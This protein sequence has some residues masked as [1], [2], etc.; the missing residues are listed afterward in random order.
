MYFSNVNI[1]VGE[2]F[3]VEVKNNWFMLDSLPSSQLE[4]Y[5]AN[6]NFCFKLRDWKWVMDYYFCT[7]CSWWGCR[8]TCTLSFITPC[9]TEMPQLAH[10][11]QKTVLLTW[12]R[13]EESVFS[14]NPKTAKPASGSSC[15][16]RA[17]HCRLLTE[18]LSHSLTAPEKP[19]QGNRATANIA[20]L[21]PLSWGI[22][23]ND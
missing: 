10:Y 13:Y 11:P 21:P 18:C 3:F 22:K 19:N 5:H 17:T 12:A 2:G 23:C 20:V 7:R 6:T 14:P 8:N 16:G 4:I 15:R 9:W 1:H